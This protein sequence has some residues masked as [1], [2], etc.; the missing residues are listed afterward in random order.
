MLCF[1]MALSLARRDAPDAVTDDR[2]VPKEFA[3][4]QV[5][6]GA[7]ILQGEPKPE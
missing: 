2:G 4:D 3:R 6:G 7:V 1:S 5:P